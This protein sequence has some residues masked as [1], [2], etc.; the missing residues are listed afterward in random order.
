MVTLRKSSRMKNQILFTDVVGGAN[1]L[2]FFLVGLAHEIVLNRIMVCAD[3]GR[4]ACR[5]D[6]VHQARE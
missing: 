5:S 2:A 6:A 4:G 1:V 3:A